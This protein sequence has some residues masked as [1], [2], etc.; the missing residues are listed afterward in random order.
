MTMTNDAARILL[1]QARTNFGILEDGIRS[2]YPTADGG[3]LERYLAILT[4]A[5]YEIDR[6]EEAVDASGAWVDTT[7]GQLRDVS[8]AT[9]NRVQNALNWST[10]VLQRPSTI[11]D[12][13]R[14]L[15]AAPG[16]SAPPATGGGG[17]TPIAQTPS[18]GAV[19]APTNTFGDVSTGL[20]TGTRVLIGLGVVALA[21]GLVYYYQK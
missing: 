15:N 11:E 8:S 9:A 14:V 13:G 7:T 20:S 18:G 2:F 4:Q 17:G 19:L 6:I 1:A 16:T 12:L 5:H 10:K 3:T 21:G